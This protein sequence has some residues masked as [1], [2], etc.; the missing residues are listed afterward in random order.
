MKSLFLFTLHEIQP[1]NL[2]GDNST[3]HN[4]PAFSWPWRERERERELLS[5]YQKIPFCMVIILPP[6]LHTFFFRVFTQSWCL[7]ATPEWKS[8]SGNSVCLFCWSFMHAC[9]HSFIH[10]S[11]FSSIHFITR[12]SKVNNKDSLTFFLFQNFLPKN[13]NYWFNNSSIHPS[14]HPFHHTN[15]KR[16][17]GFINFYSKSFLPQ[18]L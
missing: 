18:K 7:L 5:F 4:S 13:C 16:Q 9:I 10:S 1:H 6:S 15:L 8:L 3:L 11:F 12:I 17:Q 14:I 2:T